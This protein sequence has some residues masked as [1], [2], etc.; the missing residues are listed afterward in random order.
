M[1]AYQCQIVKKSVNAFVR[2]IEP[3]ATPSRM[4]TGVFSPC[5]KH[6][7]PRS[8]TVPK[9]FFRSLLTRGFLSPKEHGMGS[10]DT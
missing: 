10:Q 5:H 8:S 2:T 9:W 7:G 4:L 1:R 3:A 6:A